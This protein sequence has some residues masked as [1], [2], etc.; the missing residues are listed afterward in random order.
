MSRSNYLEAILTASDSERNMLLSWATGVG[1][2]NAAISIQKRMASTKTLICVAEIPHIDNWKA[3]YIKHGYAELLN[4]TTIICYDSLHKYTSTEY[5]LLINDE[6]HHI[7]DLRASYLDT[8]T[9]KKIVNLSATVS[10]GEKLTLANLWGTLYEHT[11]SLDE[12]I[13]VGII[14][15]PTI[16]ISELELDN[17]ERTC[18][19]QFPRSKS[20]THEVECIYPERRQFIFGELHKGALIKIKATPKEQYTFYTDQMDF[21]KNR[22]MNGGA[23][24]DRITWLR[25]GSERKRAIANLKTKAIIELVKKVHGRKYICFCGSIDQAE[26]VGEGKVIHSKLTKRQQTKILTDYQNG[27]INALFAVDMLKEG[28]NLAD[29][30]IGI[31]AQL[32]GQERSFIQ[33]MGRAL[34]NP[35][36]PEIYI[37]Y[38]KE[39]QDEEYLKKAISK[40]DLTYVKPLKLWE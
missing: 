16:Y 6:C 19:I 9:V 15:P 13:S 37:L 24:Y 40:V 25:Y 35:V 39:T 18:I 38:F 11:V 33:K 30:E 20:P 21:Y 34:R 5:D 31:I 28:V 12:A 17:A 22:Y 36:N 1:K 4:S 32:D 23:E 7:S 2:S 8:I 10:Y 27:T 29:I 14:P 3:E 26:L